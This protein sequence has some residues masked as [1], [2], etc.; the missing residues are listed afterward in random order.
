MTLL[1]KTL[2]F[3]VHCTPV[4]V[5]KEYIYYVVGKREMKAYHISLVFPST[6]FV[7]SS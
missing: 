4:P 7:V 6:G 3:N 5:H 2:K 1:S